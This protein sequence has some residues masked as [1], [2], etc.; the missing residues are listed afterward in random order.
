[1]SDSGS[2]V[3]A[4]QQS[5]S[6][7]AGYTQARREARNAAK[8]AAEAS[9]AAA[10]LHSDTQA[11]VGAHAMQ[12]LKL[13][14]LPVSPTGALTET[15]RSISADH[16]LPSPWC[17]L[18]D[19][20]TFVLPANDGDRLQRVL[21]LGLKALSLG[22]RAVTMTDATLLSSVLAGGS[23]LERLLL[24]RGA[25]D[26]NHSP[27]VPEDLLKVEVERLE[28]EVGPEDDEAALEKLQALLEKAKIEFTTYEAGIRALAMQPFD[29]IVTLFAGLQRNYT[30]THLDVSRN[31]LG[32]ANT[33]GRAQ[34][35][36]LRR[37]GA[38]I[39]GTKALRSVDFSGNGMGPVGVG[40]LAKALTKNITI[41]TV[42]L[43]GNE[44]MGD[45]PDEDEDPENQ[46]GD[47]VFGEL[48][49]SLEALAEVLKKN[50]FLKTIALRNNRLKAE[51]DVD[52]EDDGVDTPLGRFLEPFKK[53]HRLEVL[54]VGSNEL[55]P[56]G[57]RMLAAALIPNGSITALDVSDN[58]LGL[59]GLSFM[60]KLLAENTTLSKLHMQRNK[61]NWNR[62]SK[63]ATK[64]AHEIFAAFAAALS[65]NGSL[66]ELNLGGHHFGVE[67]SD[68]L[69]TDFDKSRVTTLNFESNNLCGEPDSA[70]PD[71]RALEKILAATK[72]PQYP[73]R[74]LR[75]ASNRLMEAGA[76]LVAGC[77]VP[78]VEELDICRNVIGD[79][80][81]REIA[82]A[83]SRP[84]ADGRRASLR[85]LKLGYNTL[86]DAAPVAQIVANLTSLHTLDVG[87]NRIASDENAFTNFVH[88][89]G[90]GSALR[91]V[92]LDSN[93]LG[94][95][96]SHVTAIETLFRRAQAPLSSVDLYDNPAIS[97]QDTLKLV[98]A[99]ANNQALRSV[100]ISSQAG[101]RYQLADAATKL[102]AV[103]HALVDVDLCF[104]HDM[105]DDESLG[106][107]RQRLVENALTNSPAPL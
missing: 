100:R 35:Q 66:T 107:I 68:L 43:S 1:M 8:R 73:L 106:A 74:V 79:E 14:C 104:P 12:D 77:L 54:D 58:G 97:L 71:T 21:D 90:N 75:V 67:V 48:A 40:I 83:L 76:A 98:S 25:I 81:C 102:L 101:D 78:D 70:A 28:A 80:G 59:Q 26:A 10:A 49:Q 31:N 89:L 50:K 105:D 45:A 62:K 72:R 19:V 32:A 23:T 82:A 63:K 92:S 34:Y 36:T 60:T 6:S 85:E 4:D 37:L 3:A 61:I 17:T 51:I 91:A 27:P 9:A 88:A 18:P 13:P 55:G 96:P 29:R 20:P 57:A 42:N 15:L 53:Y 22:G 94:T 44:L 84:A 30:V 41:H 33:E 24:D 99:L 103:N 65:K 7:S 47:P 69:L 46:E 11:T 86:R 93:A 5:V 2:P 56:A 52:G 87:H 95:V 64:A 16:V 38:I 39:D